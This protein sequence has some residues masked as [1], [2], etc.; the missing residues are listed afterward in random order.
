V[1]TNM[2]MAARSSAENCI[3]ALQGT[4]QNSAM[5]RSG[6]CERRSTWA[7]LSGEALDPIDKN[8]ILSYRE[9]RRA[10]QCVE[11]SLRI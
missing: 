7:V 9:L 11:A 3:A 8:P 5:S 2:E 1:S 6:T 4:E 10:Q